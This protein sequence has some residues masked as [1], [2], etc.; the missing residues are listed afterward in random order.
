VCCVGS[1]D[2][3]ANIF[4]NA[5]FCVGAALA[6]ATGAARAG[7]VTGFVLP[8]TGQTACYDNRKEITC[9]APGSPF[10]GQDAQASR[11]P[12][13]YTT[14]IDGLTVSDN[15][16]GLTWTQTADW[17]GDGAITASDKLSWT[18][19]KAF[20]DKLNAM[21]Y[22]GYA[23]WR[24]PS[25]KEL[26][27]LI[28][29]DGVDV[30]GPENTVLPDSVT[31]FIDSAYFGFGYGD[32]TAGE[33]TIDAQ[34]WSS[35]EYVSTTMHGDHTVFGVNFADGRIKGTITDRATGL[36]WQQADSGDPFDWEGALA[37][38]DGLELAGHDE[39][40]LPTAKELQSIVDYSRSP[41]TIDSPAIDPLFASTAVTERGWRA[42]L[43]PVLVEHYPS[44]R[45]PR[46]CAACRLYLFRRSAR[47]D[48]GPG[49]AGIRSS[50]RLR[51]RRTAQRSEVRRR[52]RLSPRP[53]SAR[54][55]DP[56]L[57]PGSRRPRGG[58]VPLAAMRTI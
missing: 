32:T 21:K 13:S 56:D 42:E 4:A 49:H 45:W 26:Y 35:T 33:R 47:L 15:V 24:L 38:A 11:H 37:Y 55:R 20:A 3:E 40:R 52:H 12:L 48:A 57:Q 29:F 39:W 7:S 22:G 43:R 31:P 8:D 50:R 2:A 27:S 44:E 14:S 51:R 18:D 58:V 16:T 17:N 5:I 10:Y 19:A 28:D 41:A 34:Y 6:L 36:M 53:R 46:S 23:D 54:R 9:P 30:S 25:I 1:V